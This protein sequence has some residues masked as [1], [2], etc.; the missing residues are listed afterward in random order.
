MEKF[1]DSCHVVTNSYSKK[2]Q[3]LW[4]SWV[5]EFG[6]SILVRSFNIEYKAS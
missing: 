6:I 4:K 2:K 5:G 3:P 1:Q